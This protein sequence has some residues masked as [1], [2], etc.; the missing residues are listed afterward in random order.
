VVKL[1][2]DEQRALARLE[3]ALREAD[4]GLD[5]LLSGMRRRGLASWHAMLALFAVVATGVSLVTVG[6]LRGIMVCLVIGLV[7][8]ATAPAAAVVW[9]AHRYYCRYCAGKWPAPGSN[10]PRCAR[11]TPA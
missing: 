9:W 6:D 1:S 4:P 8:T 10:C 3:H 2:D 7:L 11:P 5:R